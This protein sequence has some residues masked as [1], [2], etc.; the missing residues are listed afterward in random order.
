MPRRFQDK[1]VFVTGAARGQGRAHAVA[2]AR[3]GA[4]LA[5]VDVCRDL[6]HP[7]YPLASR[8]DLAETVRLVEAD[9]VAVGRSGAESADEHARVRIA[10]VVD[11]RADAC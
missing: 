11:D 5:L 9:R 6:P 10:V 4:D 7:R 3:A 2:F 1:V 8:E